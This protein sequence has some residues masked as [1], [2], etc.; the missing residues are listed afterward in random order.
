MRLV[1]D[2]P[3][4]VG[5][6]LL[7]RVEA[8]GELAELV[9]RADVDRLVVD[10]Y[11]HAARGLREVVH[12]PRDGFREPERAADREQQRKAHDRVDEIAHAAVRSRR[13]GFGK[14]HRD[15]D[16]VAAREWP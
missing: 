5:D 3:L 1:N 4:A 10:A 7:H 15:E 11:A 9:G 6:R 2:A 12:G 16:A 8:A 14:L 13:Y